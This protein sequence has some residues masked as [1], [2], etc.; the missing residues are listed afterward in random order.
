M[1][2]FKLTQAR[3]CLLCF[4]TVCGHVSSDDVFMAAGLWKSVFQN[5]MDY[6]CLQEC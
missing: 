5:G 4:L 2:T 3:S 1:S 6:V